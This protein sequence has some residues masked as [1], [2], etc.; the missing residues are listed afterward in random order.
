V[1]RLSWIRR[2]DRFFPFEVQWKRENPPPGGSGGAL[3]GF[4]SVH[5]PPMDARPDER[6][7]VAVLVIEEVGVGRCVEPRIA[8]PEITDSRSGLF[9]AIMP[10]L[11]GI[12]RGYFTPIKHA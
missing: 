9:I 4:G 10:V 2:L 8:G 11:S 6:V 1:T 3:Q 7:A 5:V 12:W